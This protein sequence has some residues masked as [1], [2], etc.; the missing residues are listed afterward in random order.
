MAISHNRT[1]HMGARPF[2]VS[3]LQFVVSG[4]IEKNKSIFTLKINNTSFTS[5]FSVAIVITLRLLNQ[6]YTFIVND[7]MEEED[8][9]QRWM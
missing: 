9:E 4:M 3:T 6:K 1:V 5:S 7:I 8:E 2:K